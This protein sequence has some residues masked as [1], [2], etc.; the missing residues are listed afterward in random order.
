MYK[1]RIDGKNIESARIFDGDCIEVIAN[2]VP[3]RVH[4]SVILQMMNE[5]I[6]YA[7]TEKVHT[8]LTINWE[9]TEKLHENLNK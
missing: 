4:T 8:Y 3:F 9:E 6:F 2:N 7:S 5:F 1:Q